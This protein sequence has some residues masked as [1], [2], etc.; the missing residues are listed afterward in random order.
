[1]TTLFYW[2][3]LDPF[4]PNTPSFSD[5]TRISDESE[6]PAPCKTLPYHFSL[7]P[8]TRTGI[9]CEP[10]LTQILVTGQITP[11]S[12]IAVIFP[13]RNPQGFRVVPFPITT[14]LQHQFPSSDYYYQV[15]T[16]V[17]KFCSI[18]FE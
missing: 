17:T 2:Y 1:M 16:K 4:N 5:L 12:Y 14:S 13:R 9:N 3:G 8:I 15:G 10:Y 18:V 11:H 7:K 6:S